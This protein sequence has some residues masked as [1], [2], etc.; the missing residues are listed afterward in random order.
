MVASAVAQELV[1]VEHAREMRGAWVASVANINWP[2]SAQLSP[3]DQQQEIR[4]TLDRMQAARLNA[5]FFQV[6]PEGDAFYCSELEPW[7]RFLM[8]GQ[9]VDPG[10]DPLEYVV[11]EAHLRNIEVH[12]WLNPYR[13][14]AA[15]GRASGM[16]GPHLGFEE[17]GQILNYSKLK[18]MNP[19]SWAVRQRLVDVCGDL[20]R[21][22]DIDGIHF[23]DYFYPYP[24]DGHRFE[25]QKNYQEYCQAGGQLS[26]GDWRRQNVNLAIEQVSQVIAAEKPYVRFGISPFGLPAPGRPE[27]I[28]GFDQY[29]KLYADT[30][31]WMDR[32]WV[33]Y[34][35][36]QLYWPTTKTAQAFEPLIN[37]WA[38]HS[39]DGRSIF[40]GVNFV[41]LGSQP[42]WD[43]PEYAK[44]F[45]LVRRQAPNGARG[46]ILWNVKPLVDERWSSVAP[47]FQEQN[48]QIASTPPLAARRGRQVEP[49]NWRST[50]GAVLLTNQDGEPA[51]LFAVYKAHG[52]GWLLDSFL[53][54]SPSGEACLSLAKGRW[55]ISVVSKDGNESLGR[56]FDNR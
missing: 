26:L 2:S 32:G 22:Y 18:W 10:Y 20:T 1:K 17:P 4:L 53:P 48:P 38:Q 51:R 37:W 42:S 28:A 55:A 47:F 5:I 33:D 56:V 8:G 16:I 3:S 46:T 35:A 14:R 19:A 41:G 39:K 54:A 31:L 36:P 43:L 44:E 52:N 29:E 45:Q 49:P 15:A 6:R 13:A 25:D 9:G 21:R 30:Q 11:Q 23:D 7:S 12:A 24:E 40:A 27:G 50:E 34:L